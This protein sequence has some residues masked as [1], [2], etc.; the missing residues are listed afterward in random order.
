MPKQSFRSNRLELLI[1]HPE[2][3]CSKQSVEPIYTV[4]QKFRNRENRDRGQSRNGSVL[5]EAV[6]ESICIEACLCGRRIENFLVQTPGD[7][8]A[9]KEKEDP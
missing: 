3:M 4:L 1:H 5:L 8:A 9:R 2:H 6:A 7:Q